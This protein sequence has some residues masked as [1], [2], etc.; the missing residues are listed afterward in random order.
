MLSS[1]VWSEGRLIQRVGNREEE[2]GN[3]ARDENA[4]VVVL[5]LKDTLGVL[6]PDGTYVR[7]D[8]FSSM[9]EA[10]EKAASSPSAF[11]MH[12]LWM[13][14]SV[15]DQV[16]E[17]V[18]KKWDGVSSELDGNIRRKAVREKLA[19]YFDALPIEELKKWGR[20]IAEGLTVAGLVDLIKGLF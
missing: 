13:R 11:L 6:G 10:L 12:C 19:E 9:D 16:T 3:V 7:G 18:D 2:L 4:G 5:W 14:K 15:K 17:E 20:R 8:E 1:I